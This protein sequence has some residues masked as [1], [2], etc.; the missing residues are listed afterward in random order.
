MHVIGH[1]D[2]VMHFE[3]AL[4]SVGAQHVNEQ[5]RVSLGLQQGTPHA[6]L[7]GYEEGTRRAE[8]LAALGMS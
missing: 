2:E 7:R 3:F 8:Y 1:D 4:A 5:G 6:G